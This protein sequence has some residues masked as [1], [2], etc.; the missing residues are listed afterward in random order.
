MPFVRSR[1]LGCECGY[2]SS[3]WR[4]SNN[5]TGISDFGIRRHSEIKLA[6][7]APTLATRLASGTSSASAMR[8][9]VSSRG[10]LGPRPRSMFEAFPRPPKPAASESSRSV[11]P[12]A[13]RIARMR[14]PTCTATVSSTVR[15]TP[16][17]S[18]GQKSVKS[19]EPTAAVDREHP[20][21]PVVVVDERD[22]RGPLGD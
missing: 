8:A 16:R 17:V 2:S 1:E 12:R 14:R 3:S 19:V 22:A 18:A 10:P 4:I 6:R 7:L 21:R 15:C 5:T 9:K 13:V 11:I 20:H